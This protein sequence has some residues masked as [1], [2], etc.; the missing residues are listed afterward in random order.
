MP[1]AHAAS[2]VV[3]DRHLTRLLKSVVVFAVLPQEADFF[4][5]YTRDR[6]R[7]ADKADGCILSILRV[8]LNIMGTKGESPD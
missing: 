4:L 3:Q 7:D 2:R 1:S 5:I 8:S 6:R